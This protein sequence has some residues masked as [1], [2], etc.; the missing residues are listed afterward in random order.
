MGP[1]DFR[2]SGQMALNHD[3]IMITANYV[4]PWQEP[5]ACILFGAAATHSGVG[6]KGVGATPKNDYNSH[7]KDKLY[8]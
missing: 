1:P 5:W 2:V 7:N 8:F 4:P 3:E 6:N